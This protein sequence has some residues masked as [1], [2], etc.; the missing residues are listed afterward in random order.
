MKKSKNVN[1]FTEL[2]KIFS[3][4][5]CIC[6]NPDDITSCKNEI[7]KLIEDSNDKEEI[8][9]EIIDNLEIFESSFDT[10]Q[11]AHKVAGNGLYGFFGERNS[12]FFVL[13]IAEGITQTGQEESTTVI[14]RLLQ[15]DYFVIYSDTDSCFINVGKDIDKEYIYQKLFKKFEK[16]LRD[17]Y[18][19]KSIEELKEF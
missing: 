10:I 14:N 2:D 8:V 18:N 4:E 7:D 5:D 1:L 19:I 9:D 6:C 15:F 11:L 12:R 16:Q 17:E 13:A 3:R